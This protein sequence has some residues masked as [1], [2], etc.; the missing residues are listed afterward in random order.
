MHS[1]APRGFLL[2]SDLSLESDLFRW[3]LTSLALESENLLQTSRST[4]E[5]SGV[6]REPDSDSRQLDTAVTSVRDTG[7]T[8]RE[9][10]SGV[11]GTTGRVSRQ[12]STISG[13]N[14]APT[15]DSKGPFEIFH[16]KF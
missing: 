15:R 6:S 5:P 13:R 7:N 11:R 9:T 8:I 16:S 14:T 3:N 1:L 10:G 2:E 12:E 4:K